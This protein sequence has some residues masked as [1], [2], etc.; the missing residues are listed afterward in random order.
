MTSI[1]TNNGE[2]QTRRGA[3]TRGQEACQ[4]GTPPATTTAQDQVPSNNGRGVPQTRTAR[5][6]P[7]QPR[8][9]R[10]SQA[11]PNKVRGARHEDSTPPE[12]PEERR[13]IKEVETCKRPGSSNEA[14]TRPRGAQET[15]RPGLHLPGRTKE[16]EPPPPGL[17]HAGTRGGQA[18]TK[19]AN[20]GDEAG[21]AAATPD[22]I[23]QG[24]VAADVPGLNIRGGAS[25]RSRRPPDW[26]IQG[27]VAEDA[28]DR[29]IRGKTSRRGHNPQ[30]T[31]SRGKVARCQ[32]KIVR[33]GSSRRSPRPQDRSGSNTK[34][35]A[36]EE[37]RS[38]AENEVEEMKS[39]MDVAGPRGSGEAVQRGRP[40]GCREADKRRRPR[41]SREAM[42]RKRPKVK[43]RST[44]VDEA[45]G[46][47][48]SGEKDKGE[49]KQWGSQNEEP[50]EK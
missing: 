32:C 31:I 2:D 49:E 33:G 43:L 18:H 15:R 12:E 44:Q 48:R 24:Q 13:R 45:E 7:A 38:L 26:S 42:K 5:A 10:W 19:G 17:D 50:E 28:P 22:W 46:M 16:Q 3:P 21:E 37:H 47:R 4:R 25:S 39:S 1:H 11:A 27:Q 35:H 20:E 30:D 40:R 23:N 6:T 9:G 41:R 14:E 8:H 34:D 36:R 29:I